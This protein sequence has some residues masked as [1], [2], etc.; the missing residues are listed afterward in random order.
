M[1][2]WLRAVN[3]LKPPFLAFH[4]GLSQLF[5]LYYLPLS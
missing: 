2:T 4:E 1:L 3:P 5:C